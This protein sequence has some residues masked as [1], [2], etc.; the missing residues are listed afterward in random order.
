MKTMLV[1]AEAVPWAIRPC[2]AALLVLPGKSAITAAAPIQ[3]LPWLAEAESRRKKTSWLPPG[4]SE[5]CLKRY[6]SRRLIQVR[7]LGLLLCM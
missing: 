4:R 5:T 6:L 3:S 2:R 7:P 1:T